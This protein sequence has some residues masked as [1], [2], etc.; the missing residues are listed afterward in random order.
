M[1]RGMALIPRVRA[2][3]GIAT[4]QMHHHGSRKVFTEKVADDLQAMMRAL[5]Y[6]VPGKHYFS[7]FRLP[8]LRS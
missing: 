2:H 7:S 6:A 1:Q 3:P 8:L 5:Q 4:G